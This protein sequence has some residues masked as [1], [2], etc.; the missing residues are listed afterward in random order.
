LWQASKD[1]T[2]I[3]AVAHVLKISPDEAEKRLRAASAAEA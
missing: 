3:T 1:Q 2:I